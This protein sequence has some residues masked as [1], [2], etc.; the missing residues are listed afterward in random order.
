MQEVIQDL[1]AAI[2]FM[3]ARNPAL[4][5]LL[6]VSPVPLI[7]TFEP[8]HVLVATTYSKSV[9]RVAAQA[10]TDRY[11]HVDYFPSYEIITAS[12]SRGAYFAADLREVEAAGVSHAMRCFFR[13]YLQQPSGPELAD[14]AL[15]RPEPA[16]PE[17]ADPV[18]KE[19]AAP[20]QATALSEQINKLICDEERL[21]E[22]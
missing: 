5:I 15:P 14:P 6:T 11:A 9:L 12:F 3:T 16:D 7:A 20:R 1:F 19:P 4:R 21:E 17:L 18:A 10:A 22:I 2:D 8:Q 13:N